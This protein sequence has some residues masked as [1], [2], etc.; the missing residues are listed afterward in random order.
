MMDAGFF[1]VDTLNEIDAV[2]DLVVAKE[3]AN[4]AIADMPNARPY[5]IKK[6]T[7]VIVAA[8]NKR[9]LMLSLSN[10]I[11]AHPSENLGMNK[12]SK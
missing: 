2:Q 6:A 9:Q 3:I 11:L 7:A 12:E 5:N 8:K 1:T 10:F 4:K